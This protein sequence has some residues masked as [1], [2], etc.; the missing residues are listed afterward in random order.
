MSLSSALHVVDCLRVLL[1]N[2]ADSNV[3]R[4]DLSTPVHLASSA[5]HLR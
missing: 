3:A 5:G 1:E 2:G 4:D